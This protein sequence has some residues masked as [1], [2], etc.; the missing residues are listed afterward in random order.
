MF[1]FVDSLM[2]LVIDFIYLICPCFPSAFN[3]FKTTGLFCLSLFETG[4]LGSLAGLRLAEGNLDSVIFLPT[5]PEDGI[6]GVCRYT[7]FMQCWG[8][9]V[10]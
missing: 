8:I 2:L 5:A 3:L 9:I 4:V 10:C 7:W 1:L 6:A